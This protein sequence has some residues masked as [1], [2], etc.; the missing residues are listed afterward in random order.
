MRVDGAGQDG[1]EAGG[2]A[3]FGDDF[4][5]IERPQDG[6]ADRLVAHCHHIVGEAADVLEGEVARSHGHEAVGDGRRRWQ[7]DRMSGIECRAH[8]GGAGRFDADDLDRWP[9]LLDR[10]GDA[11]CQPAAADRDDDR[12]DGGALL[13]D[14]ETDGSLAR[15]DPFVIER[16][17]HRQAARRG[18]GLGAQT[19]LGR[20]RAFEYELGAERAGAFDLD[21]RCRRRHDD[22]RRRTELPRG[23]RHRLA[24]I[25]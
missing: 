7:G 13:E 14:L 10:R 5:A 8:L 2:S 22:H 4:G 1:G 12:R 23:E 15:D 18:F 24:V 19:A 9:G 11:R 21:R 20:G 16:R 6:L 3:G 25:A 17:H